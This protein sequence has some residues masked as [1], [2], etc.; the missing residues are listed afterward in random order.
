MAV[1]G[2][3]NQNDLLALGRISSVYGVRGWVKVYSYTDPMDNIFGYSRWLL[4]QKGQLQEIA[5]VQGKKHGK[6]LV[7]HLEG[8][9]DREVAQQYCGAE[10]FIR[11]DQL[12]SLVEGEYYW[13]QLEGLRV[14]AIATDEYQQTDLG[15]VTRLMAT[16]AND[17]LVVKGDKQSVDQR[18][19]L[20]PF[21]PDQVIESICLEAGEIRIDWDPEF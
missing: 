4:K 3:I 14:I 8:C 19:R 15:R 17:V 18:E 6:G 20:I 21:L 10:V 16:G 5:V 11:K 2:N 7:A 1:T 9:D 13:H 12:P